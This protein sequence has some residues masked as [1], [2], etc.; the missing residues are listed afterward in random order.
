MNFAHLFN[1]PTLSD[2]RFKLSPAETLVYAHRVM[3]AG[4]GSEYLQTLALAAT[5]NEAI[6]LADTDLD[7]FLPVLQFVYTNQLEAQPEHL[8]G[9]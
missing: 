1:Q 5:P 2:V 8:P 3:L 6:T 7:H 9:V 4:S